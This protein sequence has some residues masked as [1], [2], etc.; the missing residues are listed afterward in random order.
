[1]SNICVVLGLGPWD[2]THVYSSKSSI[3][4][5]LITPV[6]T[7]NGE[8]LV[9]AAKPATSHVLVDSEVEGGGGSGGI[10][11]LCLVP[12]RTLPL[13]GL[14]VLWRTGSSLSAPTRARPMPFESHEL[15]FSE[16][17]LEEAKVS[18]FFSCDK[19]F[20][21]GV[22]ALVSRMDVGLLRASAPERH[23]NE[24]SRNLGENKEGMV[25]L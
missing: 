19:G 3:S 21:N 24:K 2:I 5:K 8:S 10:F 9:F 15:L 14:A 12:K 6:A 18:I 22:K 25:L 20:P 16:G 17:T 1:L 4:L 11:T 23:L 13:H 7:D